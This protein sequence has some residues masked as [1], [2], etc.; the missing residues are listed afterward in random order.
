MCRWIGVGGTL[1]RLYSRELTVP[2][3]GGWGLGAETK[4]H[5]PRLFGHFL[6]TII[7]NKLKIVLC[8]LDLY[9]SY[10]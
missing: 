4:A 3:K 5:F 8:R 2:L 6:N 7:N 10:G 9:T 1:Q